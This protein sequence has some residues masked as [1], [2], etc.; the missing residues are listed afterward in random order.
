MA[1]KTLGP[2]EPTI[3]TG[4]T[5][6][7]REQGLCIDQSRGSR[8]GAHP[9]A[10]PSELSGHTRASGE[11]RGIRAA[12]ARAHGTSLVFVRVSPGEIAEPEW[13][14]LLGCWALKPLLAQALILEGGQ[15]DGFA[16]KT[17]R[18][19]LRFV[20][21]PEPLDSSDAPPGSLMEALR[22]PVAPRE[23]REALEEVAPILLA[24]LATAARHRRR[25]NCEPS[26]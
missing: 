24:V 5:T 26:L 15:R 7:G 8:G 17:Y 22:R 25:R 16:L 13:G 21:G 2:L 10:P 11:D 12:L 3:P 9:Y 4:N 20:H 19:A 6:H 18:R 1:R 14:F 23:R